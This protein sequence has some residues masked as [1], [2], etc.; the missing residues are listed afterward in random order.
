MHDEPIK[1]YPATQDVQFSREAPVQVAQGE[2]QA[3]QI[4]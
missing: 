2:L 4:N 3:E 1:R